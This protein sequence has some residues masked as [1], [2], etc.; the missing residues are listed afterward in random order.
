M[1]VFLCLLLPALNVAQTPSVHLK[2]TLCPDECFKVRSCCTDPPNGNTNDAGI[3]KRLYGNQTNVGVFGE[4]RKF[5]PQGNKIID[6][7]SQAVIADFRCHSRYQGYYHQLWN[8]AV[9]STP[10]LINPVSMN[11][12][13]VLDQM[14]GR[15]LRGLGLVPEHQ[16]VIYLQESRLRSRNRAVSLKAKCALRPYIYSM[17]GHTT[18]PTC[19]RCFRSLLFPMDTQ[20]EKVELSC[21]EW[22][23]V[24]I[25]R[26][27]A[28]GRAQPGY[29]DLLY[30]LSKSFPLLPVNIFSGNES[31]KETASIFSKAKVVVG[32]HGAGL[33]NTIF[34]R[35]DA[36]VVEITREDKPGH[37]WRTNVEVPKAAGTTTNLYVLKAK[38]LIQ[39]LKEAGKK[40]G[41][42]K[43]TFL[44]VD[45]AAA[46]HLVSSIANFTAA[47]WRL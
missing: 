13:W 1:Y 22:T 28:E 29:K 10:L 44:P 6:V 45:T 32:P 9:P 47:C 37:V 5:V 3:C 23:I 27:E 46:L 25:R 39:K 2:S 35:D 18:L 17:E 41:L 7:G 8:C 11:S 33:V 34:S 21:R 15:T 30:W 12:T 43:G 24:Y 40:G 31:L 42:S 14:I 20:K 4:P 38:D 36:F 19:V 16:Q 26:K